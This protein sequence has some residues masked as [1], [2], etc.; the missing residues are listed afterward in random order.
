[1]L[2]DAAMPFEPAARGGVQLEIEDQGEEGM[3]AARR[4]QAERPSPSAARP[5][6]AP[7]TQAAAPGRVTLAARWAPAAEVAGGA[8][9]A[10]P[11][12]ARTHAPDPA[13]PAEDH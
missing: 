7:A 8:A 4:R 3:C 6:R 13:S 9:R 5:P 12:R 11:P 2:F 1:L 10:V